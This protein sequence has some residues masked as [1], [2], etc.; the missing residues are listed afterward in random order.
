MR[1]KESGAWKKTHS[2]KEISQEHEDKEATL[3]GWI[4]DIRDLGGIKFFTLQDGEGLIQITAPEAKVEKNLFEKIDSLN[5]GST[6]AVKGKIT[7]SEQ[8]PGGV[9]IIPRE[10]QELNRA[11]T[12]L[13]LDPSGHVKADMDTRLDARMLDLR[14]PSSSAIF[15]IKHKTLQKIR[16]YLTEKGFMEVNTPKIVGSATETGAILFPISYFDREAFLSQSPQLYKEVLTGSF[17]KVFEVGPIF[18][19]EEHSTRYHL[20]E[21][22]SADIEMAFATK[23]DVMDILEDLIIE[24]FDQIKTEASEELETLEH[25]IEIPAKPLPRLTYEEA[26]EKL[27]ERGEEIE[28]GEDFSIPEQRKLGEII[29]KPYFVTDWPTELKPFYIKPHEDEPEKSHAFD[30]LAKEIELSSGGTRIHKKELL[31]E[32]LKENGLSPRQFEYHLKNF[33]WGIPPHAGWGLGVERLIMIL[34]GARNIRETVLYPRDK[35]R[36]KP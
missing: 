34:T 31:A 2:C 33:D 8:A 14:R 36:L 24:I 13:P 30:L 21:V 1:K 11:K 10:I 32:R 22:L 28:W 35:K 26:I 4:E 29:E 19:A 20:N 3:M 27:R 25:E 7:T 17:E 18:R 15:K 5:K 6:V 23:E 12:P 16:S 9:E